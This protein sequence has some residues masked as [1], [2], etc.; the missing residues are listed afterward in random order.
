MNYPHPN[1]LPDGLSEGVF[2]PK[3]LLP[4]PRLLISFF[5]YLRELR[6]E[7]LFSELCVSAGDYLICSCTAFN[8]RSGLIGRSL[9]RKP[10]N[11]LAIALP[12]AGSTGPNA[13][14]PTPFAP[15]GPSGCGVSTI[16]E[17]NCCG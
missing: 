3:I 6:G 13:A 12:M 1:P 15:Y 14:S 4:Y 7:I 9:I 5:P 2:D 16:T 10:P 8:T 17:R 11:A